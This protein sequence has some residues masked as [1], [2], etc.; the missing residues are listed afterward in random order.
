[1]SVRFY[2]ALFP[3][4][5][6]F[7]HFYCA[8]KQFHRFTRVFLDRILFAEGYPMQFVQEGW[9]YLE[10]AVRSRTGAILLMSHLG[11]W[12]LAAHQLLKTGIQGLPGM[13]L[14]L[15]MGKKGKE[16]IEARQKEDFAARGIRIV[17]VAQ[18]GSAPVDIVEG[19]HFLKSGGLVSLTGDRR[20]R[21]DQ[22]CVAVRFLGHEALLPEGPFIFALLARAP[23]LIFFAFREGT[24][25]V[26]CR[27]L[28]PLYVE[29]KNR[30]DRPKALAEAA[31]TYADALEEA[32]RAHPWEW[33]HFEPFLG[34][35]W[36]A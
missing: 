1:M 9:S 5:N 4:R 7:Y 18:D 12:E 30:K 34:R 11:C 32:V 3:E 35:R 15:Y 2:G 33:F 19:V 26:H 25:S 21:E 23:L 29:A 28:P 6:S 36:E 10:E 31:Q 16:Q 24:G 17:E 14:L 13:R 22:R 8:W 27:M 20:W